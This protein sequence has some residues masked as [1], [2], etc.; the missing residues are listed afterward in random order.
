MKFYAAAVCETHV[1]GS[2]LA[3]YMVILGGE[4]K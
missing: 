4:K 1:C 2:A 3:I